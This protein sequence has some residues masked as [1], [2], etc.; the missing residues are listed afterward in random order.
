MRRLMMM[1]SVLAVLSTNAAAAD[2]TDH[3]ANYFLPSCRDFVNGDFAKLPFKQGHCVGLIEGL[4]VFSPD[5]PYERH[6]ACPP[7]DTTVAQLATVVVRWIDQWP[8]RWH[9]DFRVLALEA[10]HEA[11]PCK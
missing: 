11:W 1:V 4:A 9:E 3:S 7:D 2:K 5:L 10:M 6:R 8:Q